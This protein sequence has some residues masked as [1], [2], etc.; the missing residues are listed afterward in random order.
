[1]GKKLWLFSI[2]TDTFDEDDAPPPLETL[3]GDEVRCEESDNEAQVP[4]V[5]T[6]E[7]LRQ[8]LAGEENLEILKHLTQAIQV[9]KIGNLQ[10]VIRFSISLSTLLSI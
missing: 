2:L 3:S 4:I 10:I 7:I 8:E 1:M 5:D 6:N 9:R